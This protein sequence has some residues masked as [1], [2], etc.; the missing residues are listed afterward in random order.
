MFVGMSKRDTVNLYDQALFSV[1]LSGYTA[2]KMKQRM[3]LHR[4]PTCGS[5]TVD[6]KRHNRLAHQFTKPAVQSAPVPDS[7]A[8]EPA[9]QPAPVPT[10]LPDPARLASLTPCPHC[11]APLN[12]KNL[13]RHLNKC[14]K[15][16][17]KLQVKK[18]LLRKS[19]VK[20]K[21]KRKRAAVPHVP[22]IR[23]FQGGLCNGH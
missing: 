23:P 6:V 22:V 18:G 21:K 19:H 14:P 1:G 17:E 15:N 10:F 5:L 20:A 13:N 7:R 12:P 9:V 8:T 3:G 4:C 2:V 16:P 11:G